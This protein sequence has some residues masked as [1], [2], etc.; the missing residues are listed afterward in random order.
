ME[1][2]LRDSGIDKRN[3][4]DVALI[5]SSARVPIV[6]KMFQEFFTE[7]I[8]LS[9]HTLRCEHC[10]LLTKLFGCSTCRGYGN[11]RVEDVGIDRSPNTGFLENCPG[12]RR[13]TVPRVS[14]WQ[15]LGRKPLAKRAQGRSSTT[16]SFREP[17]LQHSPTMLQLSLQSSITAW[18]A[19]KLMRIQQSWAL[20]ERQSGVCMQL[21]RS[22]EARMATIDWEATLSWIALFSAV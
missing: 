2:C 17:T 14:E 4:R 15:V 7:L 6:Q 13:R 1:K 22:R 9:R 19:W 21:V 18:A 3:V 20:T 11:A 5:A 16:R 10:E 12:S 8:V